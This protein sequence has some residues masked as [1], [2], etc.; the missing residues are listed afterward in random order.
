MNNKDIRS[1]IEKAGLKYW[2]VA[3]QYGLN[4]GNFSR[5]LRKELPQEKKRKIFKAIEAAKKEMEDL[6]ESH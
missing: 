1:A 6:N 3:D 4:D 2:Q 5:L